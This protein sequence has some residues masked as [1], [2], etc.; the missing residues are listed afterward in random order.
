MSI[1]P[2]IDVALALLVIAFLSWR[3]LGWRRFEPAR[4]LRLPIVLVAAGLLVLSRAGGT[5]TEAD[6]AFLALELAVSVGVGLGMGS[7][8]QFRRADSAWLIRTGWLGPVL[9]AVLV[10]T[11]IGIDLSSGALGAP[12]LSSPGVI[13]LMIGG[14]RATAALVARSRVQRRTG[15]L[16]MIDA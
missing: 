7:L 10:A 15:S 4:A 9:W 16:G 2:L 1:Q 3:Q 13:L 12:L 8:L 6:L 11:R 5:L 14:T